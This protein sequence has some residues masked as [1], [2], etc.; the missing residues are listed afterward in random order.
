MRTCYVSLEK[1]CWWRSRG[2]EGYTKGPGKEKEY[3]NAICMSREGNGRAKCVYVNIPVSTK[4]V[5]IE[6]QKG[7]RRVS[8][9]ENVVDETNS[10]CIEE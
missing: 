6:Q 5:I 2:D 7:V 10:L 9:V 4:E 3:M 1:C 8:S